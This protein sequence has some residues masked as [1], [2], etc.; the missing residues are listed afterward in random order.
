MQEI[1]APKE[2]LPQI[3]VST[4][5]ERQSSFQKMKTQSGYKDSS[6]TMRAT[7]NPS[8]KIQ[9]FN[10]IGG[11]NPA[12]EDFNKYYKVQKKK[13]PFDK[14]K[15][16]R[17]YLDTQIET[18]L[19]QSQVIAQNHTYSDKFNSDASSVGSISS[20]EPKDIEFLFSGDNQNKFTA[21]N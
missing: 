19:E 4:N 10:T 21:I 14:V 6:P 12:L 7:A 8:K 16:I 5:K 13:K 18:L 1:E 15:K 9:R 11:V 17:K 2:E 20:A 3:R